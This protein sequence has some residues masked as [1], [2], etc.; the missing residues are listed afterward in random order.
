MTWTKLSDDFSD[1]CWRLSDAAWRLHAEGLIWSNRKL[2]DLRLAK[3]EMR[4]WAKHPE[5]A[6]ELVDAGY[7]TDEGDAYF[8]VHHGIYQRTREQV[9]RQQEVNR[10]NRKSP[11]HPRPGRENR[12]RPRPDDSSNDSSDDLSNGSRDERDRTGQD[13]PGQR[14]QPSSKDEGTHRPDPRLCDKCR[15]ERAEAGSWLCSRC[16]RSNGSRAE[17][18]ALSNEASG[19]A[20]CIEQTRNGGMC[21]DCHRRPP[22][23]G[24]RCDECQRIYTN[25]MSGY[26]Q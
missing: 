22:T 6:T 14:K 19:A 7:W 21:V 15:E 24:R 11:K 20:V 16:Q 25:V 12:S 2:L 8:I 17:T 5:A 10:R 4:L 9:Q 26:E 23:S 18:A 1:D 13:G 3:D